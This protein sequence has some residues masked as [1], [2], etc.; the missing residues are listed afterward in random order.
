M[1]DFIIRL[2]SVDRRWVFIL[3]AVCTVTPFL[4]PGGLGLPKPAVTRYT[5]LVFDE[6]E[7]LG[8]ETKPILLSLDYD[9]GTLAELQ[10]MA[11]AVLRHIFARKG[12]VI[13]V[14]FM[15]TGAGLAQETVY[16]IAGEF[17]DKGIVEGEHFVFLGFNFPF[18]ACMQGIGRDI[19]MNYP[20][21]ARGVPLDDM[22]I[23]QGVKN[24]QDMHIVLDLAGNNFPVAWISNAH[25]RFGARFAMGVT[26]VMAAD[27]TPY[28][29]SGQAKGMLQGMRG[30][31]EYERLIV[32]AGYWPKDGDATLGMDAQS[33]AHVLILALIVLGNLGYFLGRKKGGV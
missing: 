8:P 9:P 6:L 15:P 18:A 13:V 27:F 23:F 12:K 3:V 4:I 11:E 22:P 30:A 19:R 14:T 33:V 28:V 25:E 17:E 20:K 31:A 7:Q 5:Q 21:D 16:R 24:Y 26:N 1:R 32:E 10:P 29:S 2:A